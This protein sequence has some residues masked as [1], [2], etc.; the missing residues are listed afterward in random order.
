[1]KEEETKMMEINR[2]DEMDFI[3]QLVIRVILSNKVM[4]SNSQLEQL[5]LSGNKE[6]FSKL[7]GE[8]MKI[9][10][11]KLNQNELWK[12]ELQKKN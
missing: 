12:N 6:E 10:E 8:L 5:R 9:E 2:E 3:N 11:E 7:Y 1:M 4:S